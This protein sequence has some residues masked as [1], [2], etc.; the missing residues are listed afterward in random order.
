M[1]SDHFFS[2]CGAQYGFGCECYSHN[3][4]LTC[5][6]YELVKEAALDKAEAAVYVDK[7]VS[8]SGLRRDEGYLE[9]D[10][11][12]LEEQAL[13]SLPQEVSV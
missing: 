10:E 13:R 11:E 5:R 2:D 4:F 8:V 6:G 9:L 1:N 7:L 12:K 3:G